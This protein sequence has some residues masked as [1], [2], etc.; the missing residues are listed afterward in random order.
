MY[1]LVF[2]FYEIVYQV[3]TLQRRDPESWL[4]NDL[5]PQSESNQQKLNWPETGFSN[6]QRSL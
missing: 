6:Q 4:S 3:T 5:Q 1:L 2:P